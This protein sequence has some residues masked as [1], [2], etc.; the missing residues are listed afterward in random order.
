MHA[1]TKSFFDEPNIESWKKLSPKDG[2]LRF[3]EFMEEIARDSL[4]DK[5]LGQ[6]EK[7]TLTEATEG[8]RPTFELLNASMGA[9]ADATYTALRWLMGH[10]VAI[11]QHVG[12]LDIRAQ[13]FFRPI[14]ESEGQR[15]RG[16][17]GGKASGNARQRKAEKS[18]RANAFKLAKS[19]QAKDGTLSQQRLAS[20]IEFQWKSKTPCRP[21]MLIRL[22]RKWENEGKLPPRKRPDK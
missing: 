19:I 21:S 20:E 4:S 2:A 13:N 22:I 12:F 5:A 16:V 18:W 10:L 11:A 7:K 1:M 9:Q 17:G 15:R 8:L 6:E 3:I 14:I